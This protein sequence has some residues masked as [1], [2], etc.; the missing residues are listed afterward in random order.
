MKNENNLFKTLTRA[1]VGVP[2]GI[3]L[4]LLTYVGVYFILG[5][6]AFNTELNQ[7]HNINILILQIIFSG[8][9]G[10][11]L[12]IIFLI[13]INIQTEE[14]KN[15]NMIKFPYKSFCLLILICV[16]IALILSSNVFSENIRFLYILVLIIV[17]MLIG[18]PI[19]IKG[20]IEKFWI[21]EI[22][23][24]LKERNK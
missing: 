18:F 19:C 17:Y 11:M 24:K 9:L 7:L 5:E 8:I 15:K 14:L 3:T 23:E 1:L 4:F 16:C 12:F 21:K 13:L 20:I 10:F 22:N 2:V 6:F